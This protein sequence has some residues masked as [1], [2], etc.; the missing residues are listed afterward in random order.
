[1]TLTTLSNQ[2][3]E[4]INTRFSSLNGSLMTG[5]KNKSV[6]LFM[7]QMKNLVSHFYARFPPHIYLRKSYARNFFFSKKQDR[8]QLNFFLLTKVMIIAFSRTFNWLIKL[9][10]RLNNFCSLLKI[11]M[12]LIYLYEQKNFEPKLINKSVIA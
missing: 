10:F 5:P 12:I 3:V 6:Y 7:N 2:F 11:K 4:S 8:V 1:M 9:I